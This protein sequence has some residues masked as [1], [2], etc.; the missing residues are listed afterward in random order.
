MW[1]RRWGGEPVHVNAVSA[2]YLDSA[3]HCLVVVL[4]FQNFTPSLLSV[5]AGGGFVQP[6]FQCKAI[7]LITIQL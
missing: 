4:D 5:G 7:S 3:E 6:T 1:F 2:R